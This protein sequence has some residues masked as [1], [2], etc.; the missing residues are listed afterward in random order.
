MPPVFLPSPTL[1]TT[2]GR[3]SAPTFLGLSI[4]ASSPVKTFKT[5]PL[6]L[7]AFLYY[8]VLC[9][10]KAQF[11][12]FIAGLLILS[13]MVS[14]TGATFHHHL[15][16]MAVERACDLQPPAGDD[17]SNCCTPSHDESDCCTVEAE[18]RK[19]GVSPVSV[20]FQWS[21]AW[22][23]PPTP[24][25]SPAAQLAFQEATVALS[26]FDPDPSPPLPGREIVILHQAFLL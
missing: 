8:Y 11:R 7:V 26:P 14:T 17:P 19:T 15:C 24:P 18:F 1:A 21:L 13:V 12:P 10:V 23:L 6:S 2:A 4:L 9:V 3:S 20:L 16:L 25:P 5:K 22:A